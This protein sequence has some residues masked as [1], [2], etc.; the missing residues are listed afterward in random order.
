MM[1]PLL[2]L[3]GV[4]FV[5][6][7]HVW[8]G[9]MKRVQERLLAGAH[10]YEDS[11]TTPPALSPAL[12]MHGAKVVIVALGTLFV[13]MMSLFVYFSIQKGMLTGEIIRITLALSYTISTASTIIVLNKL[14][15]FDFNSSSKAFF[16]GMGRIMPILCI[17]ILAWTLSDVMATLDTGAAIGKLLN[18]INFPV[19]LL[20]SMVFVIGATLSLA[21]GSSWGTFAVI[22][23]VSVAVALALDAPVAVCLGAAISGGLFGDHASP[24]SDTTVLSS[25]CS[26]VNHMS[27]VETQFPYAIFTAVLTFI[28]LILASL[29]SQMADAPVWLAVLVM[30][31]VSGVAYFSLSRSRLGKLQ[32]E[33]ALVT[34]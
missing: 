4:A 28:G 29:F 18:F 16:D 7:F 21:T 25:M 30:V 8:I 13:S 14:K 33:N 34:P 15:I 5:A 24:I 22:I 11:S 19:W 20:A 6:V 17:L 31:L 10:S 3:V 1:Y 26:G 2:T 9:P 27:H 23:P 12:E 32:H